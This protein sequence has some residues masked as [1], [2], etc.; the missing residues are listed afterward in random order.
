MGS[1]DAYLLIFVPLR[2]VVLGQDA[3]CAHA[4]ELSILLLFRNQGGLTILLQ[5]EAVALK[6]LAK[7]ATGV[8]GFHSK[9]MKAINPSRT[10]SLEAS[11][12]LTVVAIS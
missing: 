4:F 5:I 6:S 3:K 8:V 2:A 10:F 12:A 11:R 7:G 9:H 1:Q